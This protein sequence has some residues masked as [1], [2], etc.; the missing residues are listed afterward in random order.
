MHRNILLHFSRR[1]EALILLSFFS[2]QKRGEIIQTASNRGLTN[3]NL[4]QFDVSNTIP[5]YSSAS[6]ELSNSFQFCFLK[7][8]PP[9]K[10]GVETT[11]LRETQMKA[12][13]S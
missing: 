7:A 4:L 3:R 11:L 5:G 12:S 8:F 1:I 10:R 13:I 2:L 6:L 9:I